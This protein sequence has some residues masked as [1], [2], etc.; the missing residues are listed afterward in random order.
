MGIPRTTEAAVLRQY[1]QPLEVEEVR[2]PDVLEPGALLVEVLAASVCG[3]DVHGWLGELTIPADL[4][5]IPGHEMVGRIVAVGPG[6]E[7]DSF[8]TPLAIG[9]RVIW[10]HASCGHCPG[11]LEARDSARCNSPQ[12]Y[13]YHNVD[14]FPYILGGFSRHSYVLPA[15]GRIRVPD[16]VPDE[17]ASVAACAVRSAAN[18]IEQVGRT[19]SDDVILVQGSGPVGLFATAMLASADHGRLIV[20]GAPDARLKMAREFGAEKTISIEEFPT[21]E[22]R[23]DAVLDAADGRMPNVLLEM[24]GGR[25]AFSE[26]LNLA[27]HGARYVLMGQVAGWETPVVPSRITMRNLTVRG[28]FSGSAKYYKQG[29]DFLVK[30]AQDFPFE[31]LVSGRYKLSEVNEAFRGMMNMTESKPVLIP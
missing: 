25:T 27:S 21:P 19:T 13:G 11:C 10:T 3:T 6:A 7:L 23:F 16:S 9:D 30:H 14:V 1:G 20:V 24:S 2:V 31:L 18:A 28:A 5:S 17:L 12:M 15:S 29:L 4:P 22:A 8:G 26:G